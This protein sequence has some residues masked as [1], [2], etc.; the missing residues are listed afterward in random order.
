[1]EDIKNQT[2]WPH[3]NVVKFTLDTQFPNVG[4]LLFLLFI[5]DGDVFSISICEVDSNEVLIS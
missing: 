3:A 2:C 4:M 5:D 1:M